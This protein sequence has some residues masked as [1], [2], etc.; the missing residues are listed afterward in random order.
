MV[1]RGKRYLNSGGLIGLKSTILNL[2]K[3]LE[4]KPT[5]DDQLVY[6]KLYLDEDVRTENNIKLDHRS[7]IFH[8]LNG[9]SSEVELIMNEKGN[10]L[11]NTVFGTKTLVLHGN[12]PSK[13]VLN[14]FG[15]YLM[16]WNVESGCGA[17]WDNMLSLQNV[18][19]SKNTSSPSV[20]VLSNMLNHDLNAFEGRGLAH[21]Y[22]WIIYY[23]TY[24]FLGGIFAEN[25][26]TGLRTTEN[27]SLYS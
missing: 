1:A 25:P 3:D 14:S 7:S 10:E 6:T 20:V 12:G 19:V 9:A 24:P 8:N 26:W 4:I 11:K 17:C 21:C 13:T 15:N 16:D 23:Q 27:S 2:I 18:K 22:H 5:D